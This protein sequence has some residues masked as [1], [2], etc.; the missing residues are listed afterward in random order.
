MTC[1]FIPPE[2]WTCCACRG[3]TGELCVSLPVASVHIGICPKCIARIELRKR[4]D[5]LESAIADARR[6][7]E[8][9]ST[10]YTDYV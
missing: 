9:V 2:K 8:P 6:A 1:H 10:E 3:P 4:D 7:L 5:A